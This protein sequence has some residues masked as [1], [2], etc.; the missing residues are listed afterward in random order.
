M[1]M[2][3]SERK[4]LDALT[5]MRFVAAL[6]VVLYHYVEYFIIPERYQ[7]LQHHGGWLGIIE[8]GFLGV[9]FFFV[10]SGFILAYT[11]LSPEGALRG[12]RRGFWV[13]RIARI[14]PVYLLGLALDVVPFVRYPHHLSGLLGTAVTTP[15]L[16]QAWVPVLMGSHDWN[17]PGWSLAAEA[18]FYALFPLLA[19]LVARLAMRNLSLLAAGMWVVTGLLPLATIALWM[20]ATGSVPWW[21]DNVTYFHPLLRLPE[22]VFGLSLGIVYLRRSAHAQTGR[23]VTPM[24]RD[25]TLSALAAVLL[26][27]LILRPEIPHMYVADFL[28]LPLFGA[29]IY[30]LAWQEGTIARALGTAPMVWLGEISYGVYILHWPLWW[31]VAGISN[32]LAPGS[33]TA[34]IVLP[35]YL[36]A[37]IGL[38]GLSYHLLERRARRAIRARWGEARAGVRAGK[39]VEAAVV[40]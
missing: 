11:Y 36:A 30:V 12:S 18:L 15:L 24:R 32:R 23:Y 31:W 9:D 26:G 16:V 13:A 4:Q 7:A 39:P 10:L 14:Y 3:E 34:L 35:I 25:V 5:G 22:F 1:G 28:V 27:V 38:S 17:P 19:V 29:A 40:R 2:G 20:G 6:G 33:S 37:L 21:W 8:Q